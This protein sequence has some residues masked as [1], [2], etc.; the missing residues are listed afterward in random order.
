M[1]N[2][3]L[4]EPYVGDD[5]AIEEQIRQLTLQNGFYEQIIWR[6]DTKAT[7]T[8]YSRIAPMMQGAPMKEIPFYFLGP[9]ERDCEVQEPPIEDLVYV[10]LSHY[11]NSADI[12]NGAHV[13]GLPT[14]YIT[15]MEP[16]D[17]APLNIGTNTAW[18]LPNAEATVGYLQVGNEGFASLENLM[19][20]KEQQ[21]AA[22]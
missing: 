15:G 4:A 5:G 22:L 12:E 14:P 19:D 10:N 8:E 11:M 9:K 20:R 13:S 16:D 21:M 18:I 2:I 3:W 1:G 7:W 17:S 6:K